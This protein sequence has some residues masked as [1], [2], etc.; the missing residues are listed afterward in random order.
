MEKTR[1]GSGEQNSDRN[2]GRKKQQLCQYEPMRTLPKRIL[3]W[4]LPPKSESK[5][6]AGADKNEEERRH[7]QE[8]LKAPYRQRPE[9]TSKLGEAHETQYRPLA[10]QQFVSAIICVS[11]YQTQCICPSMDEAERFGITDENRRL[12]CRPRLAPLTTLPPSKSTVSWFIG[13][14][15]NPRDQS[16]LQGNMGSAAEQ[17][18]PAARGRRRFGGGGIGRSRGVRRI[19]PRR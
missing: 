11:E 18:C 16:W 14:R 8:R 4:T 12:S 19:F 7:V 13:N 17:T 15:S 2:G 5:A 10:A 6:Q 3:K 1:T 9:S